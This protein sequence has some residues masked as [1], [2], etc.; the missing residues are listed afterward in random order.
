MKDILLIYNPKA[1]DTT[2]R[3]S[4]DRFIEIFS[5]KQW[6]I[7]VFRSRRA[8]D[9]SEYLRLCD[10]SETQAVFVAG[11]TG[12]VNEAVDALMQRGANVPVGIIPAGTDNEFA[13][14]LGFGSDLDEN[15]KALAEMKEGTLDVG[16]VN[17]HYFVYSLT[18][19]T[20]SS[21]SMVSNE[22]KNTFGKLAFYAKGVASLQ[23]IRRVRLSIEAGE[24]RYTGSF[25]GLMITNEQ[26]FQHNLEPEGA[27][28]LIASQSALFGREERYFA[29][30]SMPEGELTKGVL[31]LVSDHFLV[32][33]ADGEKALPTEMD[34][35]RGPAFPLEV[36]VIRGGLRVFI[37]NEQKKAASEKI[38][39]E[40]AASEKVASEGKTPLSAKSLV[41]GLTKIKPKDLF[42]LKRKEKS[43][44]KT[45]DLTPDEAATEA[46]AKVPAEQ[47]A[48]AAGQQAQPPLADAGAA[49]QE[50]QQLSLY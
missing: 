31:K 9:M 44:G 39:S 41:D 50:P 16:R 29:K 18:A 7:R 34:G 4:L 48:E 6:E 2:F 46:H 23:K 32:T 49:N 37:G 15:L 10:L 11:G 5:E 17:D 27:F 26:L 30:N 3:F 28:T 14:K 24:K 1:G 36:E 42:S 35:E 21:V 25:A 47:V 22:V 45:S 13:V 33:L 38:A 20:V 19:G 8:G 40:K 12:T 43:S